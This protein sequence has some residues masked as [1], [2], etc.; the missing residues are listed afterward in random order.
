MPSDEIHQTNAKPATRNP[1]WP[2]ALDFPRSAIHPAEERVKS[3]LY[4]TPVAQ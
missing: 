1:Y 2:T 3:F 4:P